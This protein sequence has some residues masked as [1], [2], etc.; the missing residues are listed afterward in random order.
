MLPGQTHQENISSVLSM[1]S[2][3]SYEAPQFFEARKAHQFFKA[4]QGCQVFEA[5]QFFGARQARLFM[6]HVS[7]PTTQA[8]KAREHAKHM[9]TPST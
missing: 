9:T 3:P 6:K 5:R 1:P 4:C 2:T 8:W 7:T